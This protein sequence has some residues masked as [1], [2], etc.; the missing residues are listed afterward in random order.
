M[1]RFMMKYGMVNCKEATLLMAKEEEGKLSFTEKLQ[2]LMHTSMCSFCIKFA[3]QIKQ[4][5]KESRHVHAEE[6]MSATANDRINKM[7]DEHSF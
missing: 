2:L 3:L 4:I 7:I 1:K 6:N 5:S